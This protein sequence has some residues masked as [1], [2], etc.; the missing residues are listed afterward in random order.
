M[1]SEAAAFAE[2]IRSVQIYLK[3]SAPK[4]TQACP[5][6][7]LQQP[8]SHSHQV[9][10]SRPVPLGVNDHS[11]SGWL[12]FLGYRPQENEKHVSVLIVLGC[13]QVPITRFENN[14]SSP[15]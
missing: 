2:T 8:P 3:L 9:P 10:D 4:H 12:A 1:D 7:E 11:H 5:I 14:Q 6:F 15:R 13:N